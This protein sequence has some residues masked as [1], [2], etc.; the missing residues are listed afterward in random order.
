MSKT[1]VNMKIMRCD[2]I[3]NKTINHQRPMEYDA[4]NYCTTFNNDG[5]PYNVLSYDMLRYNK[6]PNN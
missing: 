4:K 5:N 2:V 1:M 3:T 6:M